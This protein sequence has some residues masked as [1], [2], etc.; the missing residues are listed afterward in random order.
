MALFPK[1][2]KDKVLTT[3]KLK[4]EF[5]DN[6]NFKNLLI[7]AN[8]KIPNPNAK[9]NNADSLKANPPPQPLPFPVHGKLLQETQFTADENDEI[10]FATWHTK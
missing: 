8:K 7:W 3:F 1:N 4:S 2:D 6:E 9:A 10:A 5:A